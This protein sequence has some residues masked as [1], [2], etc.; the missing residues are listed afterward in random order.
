MLEKL[1][2]EIDDATSA[3]NMPD[4]ETA[5]QFLEHLREELDMRIDA[6]RCDVRDRDHG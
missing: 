3:Q 4:P 1:L 5:L 2:Q 6:V